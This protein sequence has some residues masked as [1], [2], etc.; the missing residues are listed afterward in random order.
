MAVT[1][2]TALRNTLCNA[3]VDALDGGTTDAA[4]DVQWANSSDT[5]LATGALSNPAFGAA[6]GG[7]ATASA[8]GDA[9]VGT[10]GTLAKAFFRNRD[11][12]EQ[13]RCAVG[14]SGSDINLSSLGV[15]IGDIVRLTALTYSAPT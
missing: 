11:N 7:T 15:G 1:H 10:A 2:A 14:T 4:G 12:T 8:I 13:F 3:A 5:V 6:S 9:T